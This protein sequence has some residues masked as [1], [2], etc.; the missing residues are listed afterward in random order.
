[1]SGSALRIA[2]GVAA[3]LLLAWVALVGALLLARPRGGLLR[4]AV[5]LLPDLLRLVGRLTAD[6][7]LPA[8]VR[9]RLG[10]LAAYLAFP[11]DVVPDFVPVLG[12]ADDAIIVAWTL[13]SVT[14][15]VGLPA[16]RR[17]WPGTEDGFAA[18]TRLCGL[19]RAHRTRTGGWVV[20]AWLLAGLGALTLVLANGWFLGTDLAVRDWCDARTARWRATYWAARG[21]NLVGQGTPLAVLALV[22]TGV[23]VWRTR[24]VRPL[25][26][27]LAAY[28]STYL[29]LGGLKLWLDRAAPHN[30]HVPHPERLFT[31]GLS[32]PSGHVTNAIV[33]YGVLVMLLVALLPRGLPAGWRRALRVVPPVIVAGTTT[34]LGFHWLTDGAAG[35]L[36]GLALDRVLHGIRWDRLPLGRR[37]AARGWDAPAGLV[38]EPASAAAG[39]TL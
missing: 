26:L 39:S 18:L 10:L 9:V 32:Y 34:Y 13:R 7:S 25:L 1:V 5:R 38:R 14:R 4:E 28:G 36:L 15:R 8:G 30:R 2:L 20:G 16:L 6:R 31:G 22:L 19:H 33:W 12:Y 27:F 37:L 3:G 21:L 17:H 35:L 23:L 29:T 11:I 24:S